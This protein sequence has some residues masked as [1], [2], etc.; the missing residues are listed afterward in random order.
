MFT[1]QEFKELGLGKLLFSTKHTL[2]I[3][4]NDLIL[5]DRTTSKSDLLQEKTSDSTIK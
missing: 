3:R 2:K 1:D 4:R 5:G